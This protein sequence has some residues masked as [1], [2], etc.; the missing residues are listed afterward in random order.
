MNPPPTNQKY[1]LLRFLDSA[2][3]TDGF[4]KIKKKK[5]KPFSVYERNP[6]PFKS[7]L[8]SINNSRKSTLASIE[9]E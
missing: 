5:K 2:R 9:K 3:N 7:T 6:F 1:S 8:N 4:E